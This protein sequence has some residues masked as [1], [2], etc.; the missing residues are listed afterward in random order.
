MT[1]LATGN[2]APASPYDLQNAPAGG[3]FGIHNGGKLI[4]RRDLMRRDDLSSMRAGEGPVW[5][6]GGRMQSF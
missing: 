1:M 2:K 3:E 4:E 5:F 6:G